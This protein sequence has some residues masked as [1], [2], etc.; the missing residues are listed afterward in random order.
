MMSLFST[1]TELSR[2]RKNGALPKIA[3]AVMLFI[4]LIYGALYLWAFWQPN[5]E[6]GHLPVALVNEDAGSVKDSKAVNYGDELY[7][8]LID[9]A[10]LDWKSVSAE[11]AAEGVADGDYYFSVTVPKDF[12]ANVTSPTG[13]APVSAQI[14]VNYNDS[15]SFLASTLGQ[16][17]MKQLRDTVRVTVGE[18]SAHTLL[19]G[20]ND[21]G[22]GL[23]DAAD[24]AGQLTDGL[25][26]ASTGL[27]ALSEGATTLNDGM[28]VL[29]S[30]VATA[31]GG[32]QQLSSGSSQIAAGASTLATKTDELA[33]GLVTASDGANRVAGG[34]SELLG[35]ATNELAPGAVALDSGADALVAGMTQLQEFAKA[36]PNVPVSALSQQF[37]ALMTGTTTLKAG[38]SGLVLGSTDLVNGVTELNAGAAG[39]SSGLATAAS[40]SGEL[41]AGAH[42]LAESTAQLS[43]GAQTLASGTSQLA[44]GATTLADGTTALADGAKAAVDGSG[45]LLDGSTTLHAALVEGGEKLPNDSA[46]LTDKKSEVIAQPI[47]LHETWDNKSPSFGEGFAPF[48]IALA[49]F[50]GALI[51]WLIMRALPTRALAAGATGLRATLT[52]LLPAA[53]IGLGQVV[54]MML[55]LVYGIGL[56]P[57]YWLATSAFIYLITVAFLAMQQAFIIVFGTAAGRVISLVL[58]MLQLSS[59]G[60][61]YPVETTPQFFQFLHPYM[62]ASYVVTGLRQLITG[63]VDYRFWISLAVLVGILVGS[64]ALSAW[65]AGRQ[66][67]WTMKRLHP[68][69][70]I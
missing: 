4:P 13:D 2:F 50:V 1:G 28:G 14:K 45:K 47:E 26:T 69:L 12:S 65:F 60:G 43:S 67:V 30:G 32:A 64:V 37:D 16:Q 56:E 61:T 34:T 36:N 68:A 57:Q 25:T 49:T 27:G 70:S 62:P 15:N 52:A 59:S 40:G 22:D 11:Q 41:A 19:A 66:R 8:K 21:A 18:E 29:N 63:G 7:D 5:E 9:G 24:G 54:I 10:D 58:L 35:K 33:S 51:T 23:R 39:L 55:V 46:S 31:N 53:A 3:I 38:T 42:T 6:M 44:T 17:A 48:F 20:L